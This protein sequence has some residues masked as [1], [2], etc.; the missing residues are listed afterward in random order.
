MLI[1]LTIYKVCHYELHTSYRVAMATLWY[2]K[3]FTAHELNYQWNQI[4]R[5]SVSVFWLLNYEEWKHE[6]DTSSTSTKQLVSSLKQTDFTCWTGGDSLAHWPP[7]SVLPGTTLPRCPRK[8][9]RTRRSPSLRPSP[10]HP[11]EDAAA[12]WTEL[13][14]KKKKKERTW[15]K[16][17][18]VWASW[19]D[20]RTV[21][22][23][24]VCEAE[25]RVTA[26]PIREQPLTS[27]KVSKIN[28]GADWLKTDTSLPRD[29]SWQ[30]AKIYRNVYECAVGSRNSKPLK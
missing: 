18:S 8:T 9:A 13:K 5:F 16:C 4:G 14:K 7:S 3:S 27:D 19:A 30:L 1:K 21:S 17:A 15:S 6:H 10:S 29:Y 28:S 12:R 20:L 25:S 22:C 24:K 26:P 11:S 2:W 23:Q